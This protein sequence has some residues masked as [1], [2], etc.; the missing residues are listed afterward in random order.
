MSAPDIDTFPRPPD[1]TQAAL[2]AQIDPDT[3]YPEKGRNARGAK[4]TCAHCPV[5]VE[6]LEYA[7]ANHEPF[8]IWG[9]LSTDERDALL[10]SRRGLSLSP[11]PRTA[12]VRRLA[13]GHT[14]TE[15][16]DELGCSPRTALRIRHA[17]GIPPAHPAGRDRAGAA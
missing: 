10:R 4:E 1:W 6:C 9:G 8:G 15:I 13:I 3:W 11:A 5:Q 16:A 7:L 17:D 2:C 14:D 12:E